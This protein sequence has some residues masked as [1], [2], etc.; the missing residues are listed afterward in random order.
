MNSSKLIRGFLVVTAV[1]GSVTV[2]SL[3]VIRGSMAVTMSTVP[4]IGLDLDGVRFDDVIDLLMTGGLVVVAS[5]VGVQIAFGVVTITA[6]VLAVVGVIVIVLYAPV[7][8]VM[9]GVL[10]S[11]IIK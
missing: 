6:L 8:V 5:V 4:A 11:N 7:K 2:R 3:V 10:Q 1:R 9:G